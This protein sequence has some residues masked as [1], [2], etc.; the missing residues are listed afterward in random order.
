M[1]LWKTYNAEGENRTPYASLFLGYVGLYHH[2]DR[3][4]RFGAG[5]L[6]E[7]IVGTHSLVSTPSPQ[8]LPCEAWL[9]IVLS[10]G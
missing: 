5:R 8:P 7:I 9:G 1:Q 6:C 2:P 3:V 4:M 10:I